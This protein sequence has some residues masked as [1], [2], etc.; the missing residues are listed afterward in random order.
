MKK[1]LVVAALLLVVPRFLDAALPPWVVSSADLKKAKMVLREGLKSAEFWPAMHAAEA[2][3]IAG[4][5]D[6]VVAHLMPLLAGESDDQRRCG[7]AR[8][9][10]RAGHVKHAEKM[11][12]IL[13]SDDPHGHVHAAESLFKV[14]WKGGYEP[15]RV[16]F[17]ESDNVTLRLMAAGALAKWGS[18]EDRENAL[19]YLRGV[20]SDSEVMDEYRIATWVL[21]RTG[22]RSDLARMRLRLPDTEDERARAFIYNGM[23]ALGDDYGQQKLRQGLSSENPAFRTYAAT[24]AG[25]AG[26]VGVIPE[27]VRLLDDENLDARIRAAQ[28]IFSLRKLPPPN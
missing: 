3:T 15:L 10:V 8:E 9:L 24:F 1:Y 21:T 27:L 28:S 14:G 18:P 12:D 26:M 17:A 7:L 6:E 23:A 25:D 19:R 20:L 5:Q 4:M 22:D 11:F 13:R 2:M 16:A